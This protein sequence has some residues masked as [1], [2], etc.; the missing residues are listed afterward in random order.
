MRVTSRRKLEDCFDRVAAYELE[1]D[2][3]L[4]ERP[5]RSLAR[6]DALDFHPDFPRPY[7]RIERRRAWLLQGV[8]GNRTIR[9]TLM[10][11]D[12]E[13]QLAELRSLIEQ[14]EGERQ[15]QRS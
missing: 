12:H 5:M 8:L 7:F 15:W 9:V 6:G 11:E 3:E 10:G 2:E 13:Q 14:S 4:A 1:L